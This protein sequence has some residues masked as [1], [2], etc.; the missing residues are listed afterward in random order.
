[1]A[2]IKFENEDK[3]FI[4]FFLLDSSVNLNTWGVTRKAMLSGLKS[5]IGKPFVLTPDFG[6]PTASSGD[7]L[8]VQQEKYRVGDIIDVGVEERSGKAYGVAEITNEQAKD[9]LKNGEVNFVS[10]SIVFNNSSEI[11]DKEGNAIITEF[12]GAHVA[13]VQEPA[14]G[15]DKAEIKG[16]CIGS[17]ESCDITLE[18][19]EAKVSECGNNLM[20]KKG[21]KKTT[22]SKT[23]KELDEDYEVQMQSFKKDEFQQM[24]K[25]SQDAFL[26]MMYN[27][28]TKWQQRNKP[29][30]AKK[31]K[32]V[33]ED[34]YKEE[35][36]KGDDI[37][38]TMPRKRKD[39]VKTNAKKDSKDENITSNK[40]NKSKKINNMTKKR[41]Q[42]EEEKKEESEEE[43][44]EEAET[45]EE[46]LKDK[47]ETNIMKSEDEKKDEEDAQ[48]DDEEKDAEE[49]EDKKD[50]KLAKQ[51]RTLKAELKQIKSK[52]RKAEI[53]PLIDAILDA[54]K[55]V[56]KI[57]ARAEYARLAK[58]DVA[59]LQELKAQYDSV[60]EAKNQPRYVVK[61]A[62]LDSSVKTGDNFLLSMRGDF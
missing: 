21:R 2:L 5:F 35:I 23:Q 61:N 60:K 13:G 42:D 52:I 57:D 40:Q 6:H 19:V 28:F 9:I 49:D 25:E 32:G 20:V 7:D 56:G 39:P 26:S 30:V 53:E 31:N 38:I 27:I 10:P 15:I 12:E 51:V 33:T 46:Q 43:E 8:M 17:K 36:E 45:L 62:S 29:S 11:M 34:E 22:Y 18:K 1:M 50:S 16:K 59:T 41:A 54:K 14:Y 55:S 48:E 58:L 4:K 24:D 37:D 44:K 3:L 47:E